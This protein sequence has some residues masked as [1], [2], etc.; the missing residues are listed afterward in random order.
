MSTALVRMKFAALAAKTETTPGVDS[1]AGTPASGDWIGADCEV[2]FDPVVIEIPEYN[3]SIDQTAS[4][5]GGLRPRLRLRMPLRGS[6]TAGTAPEWGKL[7]QSCTYAETVT[8]AAVG[9]PTAATAGTATTV[10]AAAPF[11]ATADLYRGMPLAVT[12]D[13]SFTTVI[14]DYTVGR[15]ITFGETR[16]NPLT[17][18]SLLQVPINVRYGPTSDESV[19]K[20]TTIYF[21]A[22]GLLWTFVGA[23][24]N[25]TVELTTGGIGFITFEFRA[26]FA[27]KSAT[28]LPAGAATA[29]NTRIARVPPRFVAG[30]S[31]LN[32]SLA[33]LRT[34]S[35][36]TGVNVVLPDDPESAEGY[37]PGVPVERDTQ[38][39]IDPLINTTNSVALFNAFRAGTPMNLIALI[40]ST[41]GN[42][43]ALCLPAAKVVAM[44]PGNRDGL[45][46]HGITF[47]ADGA[48]AAFFLTHF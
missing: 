11:A 6:G 39:S 13:Q 43:M 35:V 3:G 34:L 48:D 10:T 28:A 45:G 18:S 1:I 30:K 44:D 16:A 33:Q 7:L 15:V 26:Q 25:A 32:R 38:G 4:I 17:T 29:A 41:A 5:V 2:Q 21:Y 47:Q 42:R 36:N 27:T 31:Q 22:D 12:G 20:T 14:T 8:S 9:A 46:Q 40:G 23:S 24:G 37:G 19:Y